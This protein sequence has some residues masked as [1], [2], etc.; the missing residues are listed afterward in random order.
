M[1]SLLHISIEGKEGPGKEKW[2][3]GKLDRLYIPKEENTH[4]LFYCFKHMC[5]TG[6]GN[7][8]YKQSKPGRLGLHGGESFCCTEEGRPHDFTA[9]SRGSSSELVQTGPRAAL[10]LMGW[11]GQLGLALLKRCSVSQT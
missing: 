7:G 9:A 4:S 1:S 3:L 6:R 10:L 2:S 11:H 8:R 5:H